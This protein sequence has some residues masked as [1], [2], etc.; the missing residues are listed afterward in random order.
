MLRAVSPPVLS[1]AAQVRPSVFADLEPH[2]AR[3][4][5]TGGELYRLHIGD[6]VV[7][8]SPRARLGLAVADDDPALYAYGATGGLPALIEAI[9][10]QVVAS[11]RAPA[12]FDPARHLLLGVGATHALF[13]AARAVLGPGDKVLLTAPFWP[14]VPGLL[15]ACGAV[16]VEV[17]ISLGGER[18]D[19]ARAFED[20]RA[21][22]PRAIYVI[23]P[24]N[25]DGRVLTKAEAE[26][27][28]EY[29]IAR[30]LWVI[31][32]EVYADYAYDHPHV[33]LATLPEMAE[34]TLTAHSFSK[35][36]ALAGLRVGYVIAPE[37]VVRCARRVSTHTVFNVPV[38]AQRC[39]L[40]ALG[41]TA[42]LADTRRSYRAARDRTTRA[43]TAAG[44][45]FTPPDG[46]TYVFLDLERPLAGRPLS[47]LLAHAVAHGVLLAPG[48][49]FG[50][51]FPTRARLCFTAVPPDR[52]EDAVARLARAIGSF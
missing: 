49:G 3:Y 34:R 4:A 52:L 12:G 13:C 38:A 25:P 29:A 16:P 28:A 44:I 33:P 6:T 15:A 7:P 1:D 36:H 19:P 39:A 45:P 35:S 31:S 9:G 22:A 5:A 42:W 27:I 14:L 32:D 41:D 18:K 43:L 47:A 2:I 17:A 26:A 46:G 24:N 30:D 11:G 8:P 50:A 20:A 37:E 40:A 21:G 48:D 23:S 51:A 10:A